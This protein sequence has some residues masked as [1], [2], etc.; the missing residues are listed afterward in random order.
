MINLPSD[1]C[2]DVYSQETCERELQ[3]DLLHKHIFLMWTSKYDCY[4]HFSQHCSKEIFEETLQWS[5]LGFQAVIIK[6]R[7][8]V[9]V[10]SNLVTTFCKHNKYLIQEVEI[11]WDRL[12]H[13]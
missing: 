2:S 11:E 7:T 13:F 12:R 8:D 9:V 1:Y 6:L 10:L 3:F 5:A 4:C